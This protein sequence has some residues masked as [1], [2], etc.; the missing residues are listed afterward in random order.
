MLNEKLFPPHI[1]EEGAAP[2]HLG[3]R[4]TI[5]RNDFAVQTEGESELE[6]RIRRLLGLSGY[7]ARAYLALLALGRARPPEV[8]KAA[9]IP[10]Q[11]V[12]DV[13]RSLAALGLVGEEG[14]YYYIIDPRRALKAKAEERIAKAVSEASELEKLGEELSQLAKQAS[15]EYVK[16]VYGVEESVAHAA[17]TLARCK[18]PPLFMAYKVLD[19]LSQLWPVLR[20]LVEKLPRGTIIVLPRSAPIPTRY[21]EEVKKHG[22][23]L[24]VSDAAIMDLM[25]AC[26][27]VII[28]L[29]SAPHGV[30]ALVISNP[31]FT[32][33]LKK[34]LQEIIE[35]GQA[36]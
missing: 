28:G 19:R 6:T 2:R 16:I 30:I 7:E 27:T 31:V 29:P 12:Y 25:A 4:E 35:Q 33:A 32:E 11:R 18:E 8:A 24:V 17:E 34:R 21:V 10:A 3:P 22:V 9:R 23:R 15:E 36:L 13:L 20:L 14:G 1:T 5:A 26:D